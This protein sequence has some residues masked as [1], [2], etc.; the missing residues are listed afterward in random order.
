LNILNIQVRKNIFWRTQLEMFKFS[1]VI[2]THPVL[3]TQTLL[4]NAKCT[5]ARLLETTV[6]NSV[7]PLATVFVFYFHTYM[8]DATVG[9]VC[10]RSNSITLIIVSCK[11]QRTRCVCIAHPIRPTIL[12]VSRVRRA[13]VCVYSLSVLSS[14][15]WHFGLYRRRRARSRY[16][17][18]RSAWVSVNICAQIFLCE[19]VAR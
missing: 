18:G 1:W 9:E 17:Q 11:L 5:I 19:F 16:P 4:L 3:S 2:V 10:R 14:N 12:Q 8:A 7:R 6:G 15:K 13:C